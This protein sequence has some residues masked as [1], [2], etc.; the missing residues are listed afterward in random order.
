MP[1]TRAVP[2]SDIKSAELIKYEIPI[3]RT[4]PNKGAV[5]LCFLP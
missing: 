3:S 2:T 4:P 1:T 5:S